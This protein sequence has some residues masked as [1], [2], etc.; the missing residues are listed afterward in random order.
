MHSVQFPCRQLLGALAA[1][2][3][4]FGCS[5]PDNE[6]SKQGSPA[7]NQA[8]R[9]A[10]PL[11]KPEAPLDREGLILAVLRAATAAALGQNDAKAQSVLKGRRFEVRIR[12]GCSGDDPK[13]PSGWTFDAAKSVLRTRVRA[14]VDSNAPPASDLLQGEYEGA[15]GFTLRRPWMLTDGCPDPKFAPMADGPAMTVMQL[16]TSSDSRVQRPESSYEAVAQ[17]KEDQLPTQGLN[18][19]LSGRLEPFADERAIR[20]AA[21]DGAPACI[22][23]SVIDRVSIEDPVRGDVLGEWGSN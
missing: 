11:P 5:P 13:A 6:Q 14:D 10:E 3:L 22:V 21:T 16:F 18:L 1:P 2:L 19:V 9:T 8:L 20:C 4:A 15:V 7:T 12:F 23:S 17:V